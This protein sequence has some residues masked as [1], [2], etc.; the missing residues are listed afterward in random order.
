[1]GAL[2]L[3]TQDVNWEEYGTAT[4]E[5]VADSFKTAYQ[6]TLKG[7]NCVPTSVVLP[8][9]GSVAPD[10]FLLCDGA[11]YSTDDYPELFAIIGYDWGGSGGNFNVP[12][13]KNRTPV[14]AGDLYAVAQLFG[15]KEHTNTIGEIPSHEHS[16]HGHLTALAVAPGELV[17]SVP[18]IDSSTGSTGGGGAHN[19]MQPSAG[20]NFIIKT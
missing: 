3:L 1:L 14:G 11:S 8:Y 10:G 12:N 15:E 20:L 19:N 13:M 2:Y 6:E 18:S 4:P 9:A 7:G 16:V 5:D 17:V